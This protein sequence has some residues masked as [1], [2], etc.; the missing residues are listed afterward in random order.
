MQP[1]SV[2]KLDDLKD[3]EPAY[4]PHKQL[5]GWYCVS[6]TS[7]RE[8]VSDRKIGAPTHELLRGV[9]SSHAGDGTRLWA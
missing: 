3:R 4:L 8:P 5:S 2:A 6:E 7:P 9:R 1:I